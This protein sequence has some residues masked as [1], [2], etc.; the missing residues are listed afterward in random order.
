[1]LE[2]ARP[3]H[4]AG[5]DALVFRQGPDRVRI[6]RNGLPGRKPVAVAVGRPPDEPGELGNRGRIEARALDDE[7]MR[8]GRAASL[9]SRRCFAFCFFEGGGAA[10]SAGLASQPRISRIRWARSR[11]SA[12]FVSIRKRSGPARRVSLRLW[13]NWMMRSG[14]IGGSGTNWI[15]M[16]D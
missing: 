5:I 9:S 8:H 10:D 2:P 15:R 11:A 7:A 4:Q 1:V 12:V 13:M 3:R 16:T 6:Q 14:S